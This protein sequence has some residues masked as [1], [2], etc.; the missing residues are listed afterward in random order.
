M[1]VGSK[2]EEFPDERAEVT[3]DALFILS[4]AGFLNSGEQQGLGTFVCFG[5]G[6][7]CGSL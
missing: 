1:H 2:A 4:K 5:G 6:A 7:C 3:R